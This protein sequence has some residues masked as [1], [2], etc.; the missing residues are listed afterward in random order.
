[1]VCPFAVTLAA[2]LMVAGEAKLA[3]LVGEVSDTTGR[4]DVGGGVLEPLG[5]MVIVPT[6]TLA[7]RPRMISW[8]VP[9]AKVKTFGAY[10]AVSPLELVELTVPL[11]RHETVWL[12]NP[13]VTGTSQIIVG[14]AGWP[15]M[16]TKS[17]LLSVLGA[18]TRSEEHTS[19]LQSRF[20]LQ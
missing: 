5:A 17:E 4:L 20:G 2:R 9:A 16:F 8:C 11:P 14:S 1:M 10:W 6:W 7:S 15:S 18:F 13:D 19:E 12:A 3:P